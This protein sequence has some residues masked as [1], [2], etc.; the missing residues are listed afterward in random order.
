MLSCGASVSASEV[1]W[2]TFSRTSTRTIA[3]FLLS[4]CSPSAASASASGMPALSSVASCRVSTAT[5]CGRTR[6]SKPPRSISRLKNGTASPLASA[7]A[8]FAGRPPPPSTSLYSVTKM[9]SL[10]RFWRSI[11]APSASLVPPTALPAAFRPF[12]AKTGMAL[13][14]VLGGDHEDLGGGGHARHHLLRAVLAQ[15]AHARLDAVVLDGLRV[16]VL[17]RELPD[18]LVDDQQLVD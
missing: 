6:S 5:S 12:Q 2:L 11:F 3:S 17:D 1:P 4:A 16:R 13:L 14:D 8:F 7:A 10:R 15:R 9:P 18:L